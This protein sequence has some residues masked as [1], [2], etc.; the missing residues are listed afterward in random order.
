ME[1]KYIDAAIKTIS[2]PIILKKNFLKKTRN[3]L[4]KLIQ[5]MAKHKKKVSFQSYFSPKYWPTW[6]AMGCLWLLVKIFPIHV[7]IFIGKKFGNLLYF[8][9]K[10]RRHIAHINL[11]YCFPNY[12]KE[13][14]EILARQAFES[15]GIGMIETAFAWWMPTRRLKKISRID[16]WSHYQK[17]LD[18][19]RPIILCTPHFTT[20]EIGGRILADHISYHAVYRAQK[21]L[22][23]NFLM[24][25]AR[26][27][28]LPSI[29]DRNDVRAML[30]ALKGSFPLWIAP[31]QDYGEKRSVFVP[32]FNVNTACITSVSKLAKLSNAIVLPYYSYRKDHRY[33][34]QFKPPL[35]DFP[36]QDLVA[37]TLRISQIMEDGI[38]ACPEQYLWL[39][40][41]FKTRP[42]GEKSLY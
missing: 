32:F 41:R 18:S 39:H 33:V 42:P 23:Y 24:K 28:H 31:D 3:L 14:R 22:A 40:R 21:N 10:Y 26:K 30:N 37:D 9:L 5:T 25:Q 20:L 34:V 11:Q 13:N 4:F 38:R 36:T 27:N 12:S 17:A 1:M 8:F 16:G 19:Q 7:N 35:I 15:V 6:F 29:I 2:H